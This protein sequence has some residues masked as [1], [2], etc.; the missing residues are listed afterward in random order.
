MMPSPTAEPEKAFLEVEHP[1]K[2]LQL[3]FRK[4][5]ESAYD[6]SGTP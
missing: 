2:H 4:T 3:H 5:S 6:L 1:R